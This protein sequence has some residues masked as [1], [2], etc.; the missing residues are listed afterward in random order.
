LNIHRC[1]SS[2]SLDNNYYTTDIFEFL[3]YKILTG[4]KNHK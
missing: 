4:V 3:P 1:G 2:D